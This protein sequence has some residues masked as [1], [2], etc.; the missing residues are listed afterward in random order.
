MAPARSLLTGFLRRALVDRVR[1]VFNDR[2]NG[3]KPVVRS[4]NALFPCDSV[5]WRVHGDVT[6]MMVGGVS[7]LLMQML[8]P[9]A[10]AGIWD[11]STFRDDMLGRLR[12]TARFIAVTTYADQA[13]ALA[14]VKRVKD[15]HSQVTGTL[16]D[17]TPYSANEPH[18]LAWVHVTEALCFLDAWIRYGEPGMSEA[19]QDSYFAQF[20]LIAQMLGADPVPQTRAKAEARV[21]TMRPALSADARTKEIAR[22]VLRQK[23]PAPAAAPVQAMIMDAAV[24]L[25]P[26]WAS[27]LHGIVG[28]RL[29]TPAARFSTALIA[30][31]I[32]WAFAG[33]IRRGP[34]QT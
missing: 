30:R 33:E 25:L 11:H 19:D 15:V 20:A 10:L 3:E 1:A 26:P 18:L 34:S 23:A 6:T 27:G 22:L 14:A 9:A 32:R 4:S 28:P 31:T 13:D 5:I 17:G 21:E 12:R 2:A 24:D 16:P 29:S 7:A 8:H